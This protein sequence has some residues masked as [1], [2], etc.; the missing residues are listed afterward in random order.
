MRAVGCQPVSRSSA[1]R[2]PAE[3]T[4]AAGSGSSA[5]SGAGLG[6]SGVELQEEGASASRLTSPGSIPPNSEG[7]CR[8]VFEPNL[9]PA[10]WKASGLGAA[11]LSDPPRASTELPIASS[12]PVSASTHPETLPGPSGGGAAGHEE[13]LEDPASSLMLLS[14]GFS[15]G[16]SSSTGQGTNETTLI[17][18]E[19][20][21]LVFAVEQSVKEALEH[22]LGHF[23]SA[24]VA[25]SKLSEKAAK[26]A[27]KS[28]KAAQKILSQCLSKVQDTVESSVQRAFAQP[29]VDGLREIRD[30]HPASLSSSSA[31]SA[32]PQVYP[33]CST[34]LFSLIRS[35][36]DATFCCVLRNS[37]KF[38][39]RSLI[40]A[41][42]F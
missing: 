32:A 16:E 40:F 27:V 10:F 31:V 11:A 35:I 6:H 13:S 26:E 18:L 37:S 9:P 15:A 1:G 39:F 42:L 24:A 30:R 3:S 38:L 17:S 8:G 2:K 5:S 23:N 20:G 34:L 19:P 21:D 29:P 14:Q 33:A 25:A 41:P 12:A 28:S 22:H 36:L 7:R 4:G